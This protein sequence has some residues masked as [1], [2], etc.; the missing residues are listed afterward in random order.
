MDYKL[1]N[2]ICVGAQKAG[3]TTLHDILN[4]H[5]DIYLP[6]IK[7][8]KF[9]QNNKKYRKGLDF[10]KNEFFSNWN[11]EKIIGEIDPS[12]MYFDY[13]PERIYKHLG[14]DLKLIFILRNPVDRAYSHYWMSYRRGYEKETFENAVELEPTRLKIDEFHK[15]H[16]SYISRGLY[17]K[18][19]KRY[20]NYFSKRNMFFIIFEEDFIKKREKTIKSLLTFLGVDTDVRLNLDIR[21]NP[22][23]LPRIEFL[24]D[25]IYKP[26]TI[27]SFM[28]KILPSS[29]FIRKLLKTIDNLNQKEIRYSIDEK[30]KKELMQ[31]YFINDI[32]ELE[33][34]IERNLRIWY[35]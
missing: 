4:Q 31:K 15:L 25:F 13:V 30:F 23:S 21:R 26:N 22:S 17:A 27:K 33:K 6:K 20:L 9:F 8:T 14:K 2:F 12:Y 18:Q 1:P 35:E 10:Y 28:K 3:T 29:N 11:G 5:P 34:I 7:E 24:R 19:L 32:K 16:F